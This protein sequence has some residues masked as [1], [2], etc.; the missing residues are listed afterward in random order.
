MDYTAI[1]IPLRKIVRSVHLESKKIQKECGL[2]I[3]QLLAI[4][5]LSKCDDFKSSQLALRKY[6]HLN[7]STVTGIIT[8]LAVKGL[9]AK[10][11]SAGDKRE[12]WICLTAQGLALLQNSPPLLQEKLAKNISKLSKDEYATVQKGLVL[13]LKILNA[14]NQEAPPLN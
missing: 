11:P 13:L 5:Y 2:S 8:R 7:S 10:I 6:L 9:V 4:N 14:E 12:T 1:L 3:P